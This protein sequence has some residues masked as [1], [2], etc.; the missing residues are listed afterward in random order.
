M[1][2][3]SSITER[4]RRLAAAALMVLAG[5]GPDATTPSV[6]TTFSPEMSTA[7][8]NAFSWRKL[9]G[10]PTGTIVN[11]SY[12]AHVPRSRYIYAG[13]FPD[14]GVGRLFRFDLETDRWAEISTSGWPSGKYRHFVIDEINGRLVTFW[15]GLGQAWAVGLEGGAW[16]PVGAAGEGQEY[17]EGYAFWNPVSKAVSRFAG[18]GFFTFK[19]TLWELGT[20]G[21]WNLIPTAA[22]KPSPRFGSRAQTVDRA[23][24][25]AYFAEESRGAAGLSDDLWELDLTTLQWRNLIPLDASPFRRIGSGLTSLAPMSSDLLRF[26]G[27]EAVFGS[28]VHYNDVLLYRPGATDYVRVATTGTPPEPRRHPGV[29]FDWA[30]QRVVVIG[31]AGPGGS[32]DDV[33]ELRLPRSSR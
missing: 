14:Y 21:S 17:Y 3:P 10:P 20:N 18:Y 19:N 4:S 27:Q 5:C 28:S 23:K 1:K 15:D 13:F 30:R 16:F 6:P 24:L 31:G 29:F 33:W 7:A 9:A 8:G 22:P 2:P 25:R 11:L 26:G 12:S 32:F